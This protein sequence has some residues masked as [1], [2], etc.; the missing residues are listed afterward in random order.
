MMDFIL[1]AW[2]SG[3]I[4]RSKIG[5]SHIREEGVELFVNWS[6]VVP[7]LVPEAKREAERL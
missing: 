7:Q 6:R 2:V 5:P 3:L 4:E 1:E